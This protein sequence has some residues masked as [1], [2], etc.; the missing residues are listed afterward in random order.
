MHFSMQDL[1][2]LAKVQFIPAWHIVSTGYTGGWL[3]CVDMIYLGFIYL[4]NSAN[5]L[6]QSQLGLHSASASIGVGT[7]MK[8]TF[9]QFMRDIVTGFRH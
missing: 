5:F 6:Y 7:S 4:N 8:V 3:Y 1:L 2:V 9:L